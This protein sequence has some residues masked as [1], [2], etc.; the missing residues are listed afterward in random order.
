MI[1][2]PSFDLYVAIYNYSELSLYPS[3]GSTPNVMFL[4][5]SIISII[6]K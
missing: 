5:P 3:W 4:I 2:L 6:S 1:F